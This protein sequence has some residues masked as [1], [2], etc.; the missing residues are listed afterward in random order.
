MHFKSILLF[1]AA[2]LQ[3][4]SAKNF[5]W[6]GSNEAGAEFGD[7]KLPGRLGFDYIWPT[8]ESID[9]SSHAWL[10]AASSRDES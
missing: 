4:A 10:F 3:V 7:K 8:N 2:S 6:T 1:V 5:T 9:V